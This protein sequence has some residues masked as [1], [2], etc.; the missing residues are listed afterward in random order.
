MVVQSRAEAH[1]VGDFA[2]LVVTLAHGLEAG[3]RRIGAIGREHD[4]VVR[5]ELL[6]KGHGGLRAGDHF[7]A[8]RG[9]VRRTVVGNGNDVAA[10]LG[11][12]FPQVRGS[13]V[14]GLE[15]LG[16]LRHADPDEAGVLHDVEDVGERHTRKRVPQ[17][18]AQRPSNVL[19]GG[20]APGGASQRGREEC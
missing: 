12:L 5:A 8:P 11:C 4:Q 18:G 6:E 19:V 15:D 1:L 9:V 20:Q 14:V 16:K 7:G 13:Y 10:A 2:E 17:V 3:L